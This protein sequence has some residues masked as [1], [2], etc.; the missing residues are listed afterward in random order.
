LEAVIRTSGDGVKWVRDNLG[1]FGTFEEMDRLL[2]QAPDNE[3]VYL[4][5]AFVGL[6]APYWDPGARAAITGLSR[7]TGKAHIVRAAVE[8]MAF[9][10]RDALELL[11]AETGIRPQQL[12]ADG[13]GSDNPVLM[14]FQASLLR[15]PVV[16]LQETELSA[17]GSVY[18][19][20]LGI[21]LWPSITDIANQQDGCRR[22]S[23]EFPAEK[24]E[25]YYHGW[26]RAVA[27]TRTR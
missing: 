4:V 1:L 24:W 3:G 18:A 8:S 19:G 25:R 27:S 11:E 9:Q 21:G 14:Q 6:G 7:S 2:A 20:G 12:R 5:P 23:P 10:V 15:L 13:G 22:Y 26:K 17:L 16:K